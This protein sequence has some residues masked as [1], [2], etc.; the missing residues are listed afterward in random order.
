M[1]T[2]SPLGP[3]RS[4]EELARGRRRALVHLLVAV[5]ALGLALVA[6]RAVGDD[7]LVRTY[8]LAG[9]LFLLGALGPMIRMS[10]TEGSGG[11]D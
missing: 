5:A 4:P 2:A 8:V 1:S 11:A 10:R 3:Y 6:H 9:G 7:Q